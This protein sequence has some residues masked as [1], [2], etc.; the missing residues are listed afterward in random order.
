MQR[1]GESPSSESRT[2]SADTSVGLLLQQ[3]RDRRRYKTGKRRIDH[4]AHRAKGHLHPIRHDSTRLGLPS[5]LHRAIADL[6][7]TA[8]GFRRDCPHA[9]Q[10]D[11]GPVPTSSAVGRLKRHRAYESD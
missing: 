4:R 5:S 7:N 10:A 11:G 9:L 6:T 8:P 3:Q 1:G 2:P